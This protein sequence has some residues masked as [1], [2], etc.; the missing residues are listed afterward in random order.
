[1]KRIAPLPDI[2]RG[3]IFRI[4]D[5]PDGSQWVRYWGAEPDS[6]SLCEKSAPV[7]L[8]LQEFPDHP[9]RVWRPF[10]N[11]ASANPLNG[12]PTDERV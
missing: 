8:Y 6:G 9:I 4:K 3:K 5:K 10:E 2:Q 7:A 1:M 12:V 11:E